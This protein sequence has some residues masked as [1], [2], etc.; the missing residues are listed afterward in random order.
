MSSESSSGGK[1]A[2]AL[3]GYTDEQLLAILT[4]RMHGKGGKG[5]PPP[6]P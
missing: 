5:A 6:P 4:E 1:D 2:G 3:S